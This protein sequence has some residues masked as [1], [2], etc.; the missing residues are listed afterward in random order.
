MKSGS[1]CSAFWSG[2]AGG[3][4]SW[5]QEQQQHPE[6][7][8]ESTPAGL[9][10]LGIPPCPAGWASSMSEYSF[11]GFPPPCPPC[12]AW[13]C[14][15]PSGPLSHHHHHHPEIFPHHW[16]EIGSSLSLSLSHPR[17]IHPIHPLLPI[18]AHFSPLWWVFLLHFSWS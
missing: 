11:A 6:A 7:G 13:A 10:R 8:R 2:T 3:A 9:L 5:G 14:F 17:F 18:A 15:S 1:S 12:L 16:S 4:E